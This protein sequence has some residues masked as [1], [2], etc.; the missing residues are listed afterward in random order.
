[1]TRA[2]ITVG[3]ALRQDQRALQDAIERLLAQPGQLA[4][5][6]AFCEGNLQPL[7]ALAESFRDYGAAAALVAGEFG[8]L[9]LGSM[10]AA[11][12]AHALGRHASPLCFAG[13]HALAPMAIA[14][15]G[16][17]AQQWDWLPVIAR[18]ERSIAVSLRP[19]P[20][21]SSADGLLNGW[22]RNITGVLRW[23]ALIVLDKHG[24]AYIV[25]AQEGLH[26]SALR[27]VD[28]SRNFA[29]ARLQN[30]RAER[31]DLGPPAKRK[32]TALA[33]LLLAAD[34]LGA[35]ESLVSLALCYAVERHQ[36]GRPIAAF[37]AIKHL[38]ADMAAEL[39]MARSLFWRAADSHAADE[40][41]CALLC[42]QAKAY[43]DEVAQ[44]VSRSVIEVH[45]AMGF[46]DLAGLHFWTK[47]IMVNRSIDETPTGLRRAISE[48]AGWFV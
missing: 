39:E 12:I 2:S 41:G 13:P 47:R 28:R 8:G 22:A 10:E 48:L 18:G 37:Q 9:D 46:T 35:C 20:E 42:A 1:M 45:G 17:R 21:L 38:C 40:E 6:R 34:S 31:L 19:Q 5:T 16:S 27:S 44:L 33:R 43:L 3:I 26:W 36:F 25:D 4:V 23:D 32:L 30:A 7:L 11:L 29:D 15:G 14:L 24:D